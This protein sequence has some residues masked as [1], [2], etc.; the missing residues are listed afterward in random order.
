MADE[1]LDLVDE[2]DDIVG[3]VWKHQAH[4]NPKLIHRE[5]A[6]AVFNNKGEVLLQ[7]RSNKKENDPGV[8]KTTAAGHVGRG[9]DP[10]DAVIREVSE[11]LGI[12][13][14]PI[15]Y[16]KIFREQLE[17]GKISESRFFWI[18]YAIVDGDLEIKLDVDEVADARWVKV[19]QLEDFSRENKYT[20]NSLS[21]KMIMELAEKLKV[22]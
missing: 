20:L 6:I 4:G 9:E 18:Y 7:Q 5:V 11:E 2:N 1:L 21:H 13:V 8:W 12:V 14:N 22:I 17:D 19:R 15:F 3:E 10:K 16:K